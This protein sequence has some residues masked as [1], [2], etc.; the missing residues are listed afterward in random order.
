[1]IQKFPDNK[2]LICYPGDSH[3]IWIERIFSMQSFERI[4]LLNSFKSLTFSWGTLPAVQKETEW[5]RDIKGFIHKFYP[6]MNDSCL[7]VQLHWRPIRFRTSWVLQLSHTFHKILLVKAS[8]PQSGL[9]HW[10]HT[11]IPPITALNELISRQGSQVV[12]SHRILHFRQIDLILPSL[13]TPP[14]RPLRDEGW[15]EVILRFCFKW[16]GQCLS[17]G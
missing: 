2:S 3:E 8:P 6:K 15:L 11:S 5:K 4:C 7:G 17:V 16:T 9:S 14:P 12:S 13:R 1:M 10:I